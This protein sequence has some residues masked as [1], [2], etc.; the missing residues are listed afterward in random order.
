MI[1]Q[2]TEVCEVGASTTTYSRATEEYARERFRMCC[3]RPEVVYAQLAIDYVITE[4]FV[5]GAA[6]SNKFGEDWSPEWATTSQPV[7]LELV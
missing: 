2:V 5:R 6:A 7:K 1:Y 4:Q 3:E